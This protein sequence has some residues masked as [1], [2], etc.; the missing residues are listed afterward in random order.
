MADN[1]STSMATETFLILLSNVQ[2]RIGI[3]LEVGISSL[4][5]FD[6]SVLILTA[7]VN[8]CCLDLTKIVDVVQLIC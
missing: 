6:L 3:R 1:Q 4:L 7:T 5:R 8:F 2:S